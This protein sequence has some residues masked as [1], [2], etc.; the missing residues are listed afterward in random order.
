MT[1]LKTEGDLTRAKGKIREAWGDV[2]DD[3]VD[4]AQGNKDQLIGTIKQK[5]GETADTIREKLSR[6]L[7]EDHEGGGKDTNEGA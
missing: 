1:D 2:T 5:T 6:L 4:R 3:D 7:G